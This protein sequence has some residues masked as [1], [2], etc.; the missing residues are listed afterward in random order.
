MPGIN[1]AKQTSPAMRTY[2]LLSQNLKGL[3]IATL[4]CRQQQFSNGLLISKETLLHTVEAQRKHWKNLGIHSRW[5]KSESAR[6]RWRSCFPKGYRGLYSETRTPH[7][8]M[9][10]PFI[11]S[12]S[13]RLHL[14][15]SKWRY[16]RK[17][18]NQI[19]FRS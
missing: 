17:G 14:Q 5:N 13:Q 16:R 7:R 19:T 2:S 1:V 11:R 12:V 8:K 10:M 6:D 3:F 15:N 9:T 4:L 18:L